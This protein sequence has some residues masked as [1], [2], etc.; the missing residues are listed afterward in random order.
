MASI[1]EYLTTAYRPDCD[2]ANGVVEERNVGQ[3]DH[4]KL[5]FRIPNW[6]WLRGKGLNLL[7]LPEWRIRIAEPMF[8]LSL[9]RNRKVRYWWIRHILSSKF[10]L[11]TTQWAN[12][13][14]AWTIISAWVSKTS[15]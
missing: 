15:G 13:R 8:P 5:Q 12:S 6:F 11:W 1:H 9:Y 7:A 4:A 3:K 14:H 2:Y 10:S